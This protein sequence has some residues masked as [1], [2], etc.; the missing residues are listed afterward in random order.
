MGLEPEASKPVAVSVVMTVLNE[1]EAVLELLD[2][3]LGGTVTPAQIVVSDGGSSDGSY[4]LLEDYALAH[5][6]V[7]VISAPGDRSTG[8]NA[9]IRAAVHDIIVCTDGG[10]IAEPTWLEEIIRPFQDGADWV[11]GFYRP[12]GQTRLST[13]IG[14]TMVF[15]EE[16]VI[17]PDF[18]PSARSMAFRRRLWEE[19]GGFPDDA[20]L[21][22]DTPFGESLARAGHEMVFAGNAVVEWHPPPTLRA[23]ARTAFAWARGDGHFGLRSINY[24]HL[25]PR[26]LA[27]GGLLLLGIAYP[28]LL[29]VAFLP[30]APMVHRKSRL[31]YRHMEGWSRWLWIPLAT[32]NS[33][34]F[35]LAGY[36]VGY[37]E[38]RTGRWSPPAVPAELN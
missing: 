21:N 7:E 34:A 30:L 9:A 16:E 19:V 28:I 13:A 32:V 4:Q 38:R 8:R 6:Q 18:L 29:L 5:P 15:V 25:F 31:K 35:S 20:E 27:T 12:K 23:Q 37:V 36:I 22:E 3:I 33:L 17:F 10:C 2:S 24:R 14:L 11:G 26:F 1:G